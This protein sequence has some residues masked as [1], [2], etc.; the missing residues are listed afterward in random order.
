[1]LK[2]REATDVDKGVTQLCQVYAGLDEE[3]KL[4][5]LEN[6]FKQ[7]LLAKP[8]RLADDVSGLITGTQGVQTYI[9][10]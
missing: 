5:F 10:S 1:L 6:T 7:L 8:L 3:K 9:M 4:L 2:P